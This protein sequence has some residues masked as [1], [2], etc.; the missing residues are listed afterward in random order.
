MAERDDVDA[1]SAREAALSEE[2][3]DKQRQR[4]AAARLLAE[5]RGEHPTPERT[6]RRASFVAVSLIGLA[7]AGA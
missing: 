7:V 1:L 3:A 5:A 2:V 4:D 6:P